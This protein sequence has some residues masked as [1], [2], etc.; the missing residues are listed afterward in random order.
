MNYEF[1][2]NKIKE[3]NGTILKDVN[4]GILYLNQMLN[5]LALAISLCLL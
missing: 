2:V 3:N 5:I 4:G 1:R